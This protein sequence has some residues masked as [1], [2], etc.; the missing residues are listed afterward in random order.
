MK[1][2]GRLQAGDLM[3]VAQ[4]YPLGRP[5]IEATEITPVGDRDAE[6]TN[7]ALKRIEK[8]HKPSVTSCNSKKQ[9]SGADTAASCGGFSPSLNWLPNDGLHSLRRRPARIAQIY[10]VVLTSQF[11]PVLFDEVVKSLNSRTFSRIWANVHDLG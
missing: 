10:L 11:I 8:G 7:G 6:I 2:V 5:A 3:G 4:A 9:R 1:L